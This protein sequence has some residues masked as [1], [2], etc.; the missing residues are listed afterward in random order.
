MKA[1]EKNY[2]STDSFGWL[3]AYDCENHPPPVVEEYVHK[4]AFIEKA[5]KAFC[6]VCK[7]PNCNSKGCSYLEDFRENVKGE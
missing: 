6:N 3:E 5:C 2:V 1:P 7:M 4:D